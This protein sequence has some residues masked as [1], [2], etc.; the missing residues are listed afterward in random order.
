MTVAAWGASGVST[1]PTAVPCHTAPIADIIKKH[2]LLYHLFD[3]DTQLYISFSS[4]C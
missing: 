3:D 1:G 4:D 2:N